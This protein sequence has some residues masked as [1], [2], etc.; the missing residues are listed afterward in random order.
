VKRLKE[1]RIGR[2]RYVVRDAILLRAWVIAV[3]ESLR[4]PKT[5]TTVRDLMAEM[6]KDKSGLH[7]PVRLALSTDPPERRFVLLVDQFEE[8]FTECSD[9]ALRLSFLDNLI[10]A[11][12]VAQ[13]KTIVILTMRADFY[14]KCAAHPTLAAAVTDHQLLI[15]PM[16]DEELRSAATRRRH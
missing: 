4:L 15:G 3:T 8:V 13:G 11:S 9:E 10:Y 14:G 5:V 12:V 16:S 7:L 2:P 1:V 6:R